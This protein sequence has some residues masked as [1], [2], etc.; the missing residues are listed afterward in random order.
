MDSD[1]L[2]ATGWESI[3]GLLKGTLSGDFHESVSPKYTIRAVSNFVENSR[4]NSQ[5]KGAVTTGK[6]LQS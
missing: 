2:I 3:P 6:I 4:R 1:E 5:L